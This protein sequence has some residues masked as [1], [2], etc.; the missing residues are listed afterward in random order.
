MLRFG[1]LLWVLI[2]VA[3]AQV[4]N[5]TKQFDWPGATETG[6]GINVARSI[7]ED[8]ACPGEMPAGSD[9][10]TRHELDRKTVRVKRTASLCSHRFCAP[11]LAMTEIKDLESLPELIAQ[12]T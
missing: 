2:P 7:A 5:P 9:C 11:Q 10:T 8:K 4:L 6:R 3:S 12:F 1:F